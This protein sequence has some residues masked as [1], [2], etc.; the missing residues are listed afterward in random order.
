MEVV[1]FLMDCVVLMRVDGHLSLRTHPVLA[2]ISS[3]T[4]TIM[5]I[6]STVTAHVVELS[7]APF[8]R[9]PLCGFAIS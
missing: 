3:V 2:I 8:S 6:R 4:D 5:S 1:H 7:E 9:H